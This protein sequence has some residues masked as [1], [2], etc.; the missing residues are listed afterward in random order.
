MN[1]ANESSNV[2]RVV[3]PA[4][5]DLAIRPLVLAVALIAF[6]IWCAMDQQPH[7]PFDDDMNSWLTWAMNFYGQFAFPAIG[8]IPLYFGVRVLR[9]KMVADEQGVGFEGKE[10]I[11]WS[12]VTGL[13]ASELKSKQ[14]LVLIHSQGQ[15]YTLDGFDLRNFRQLVDFIEARVPHAPA[16]PDQTPP[17]DES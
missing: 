9:R 5:L 3:C 12:A 17:D 1:D 14:I 8:L 10:K 2:T 11:A 13:D 7:K 6:G 15:R 4:V 16:Q